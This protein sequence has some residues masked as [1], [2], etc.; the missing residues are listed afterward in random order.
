MR[1]R[2][3]VCKSHPWQSRFETRLRLFAGKVSMR[4]RSRTFLVD[5]HI[6]GSAV[7]GGED[8][9]RQRLLRREGDA[10]SCAVVRVTTRA[11]LSECALPQRP[12]RTQAGWPRTRARPRST[13][14]QRCLAGGLQV[15][16]RGPSPFLTPTD[17]LVREPLAAERKRAR[18][19]TLSAHTSAAHGAQVRVVRRPAVANSSSDASGA[20]VRWS[21]ARA[22]NLRAPRT[23]Q[24]GGW[25]RTMRQTQ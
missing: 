11:V 15:A 22:S 10:A 9:S 6:L 3:L 21:N 18:R 19:A 1:V 25:V 20:C 12:Q 16:L 5:A 23:R 8:E 2:V 14:G 24:A 13:D 7:A 4:A 17:H